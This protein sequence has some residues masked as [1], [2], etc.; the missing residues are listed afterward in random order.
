MFLCHSIAKMW[1]DLQYVFKALLKQNSKIGYI[2]VYDTS[3]EPWLIYRFMLQVVDLFTTSSMNSWTSL[4]DTEATTL[5]P[6]W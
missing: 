2:I 1:P 6:A 4:I 5:L 3:F